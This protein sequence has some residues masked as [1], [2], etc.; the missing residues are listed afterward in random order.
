MAISE[1]MRPRTTAEAGRSRQIPRQ[2]GGRRGRR[3]IRDWGSDVA[4]SLYQGRNLPAIVVLTVVEG[5]VNNFLPHSGG[6]I[7]QS[8][9][10]DAR[11][12]GRCGAVT[13][14]AG[15]A[16]KRV[17]ASAPDPS[18]SLDVRSSAGRPQRLP[19][20]WGRRFTKQLDGRKK[21]R[22]GLTRAASTSTC[23]SFVLSGGGL[24]VLLKNCRVPIG[25]PLER[26]CAGRRG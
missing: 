19:A 3:K 1:G 23:R 9:R 22:R 13:P 11:R 12:R 2:A 26:P 18:P 21:G 25:E 10:L 20:G 4:A 15:D 5:Q 6:L 17:I 8:P 14:A 16:L 7:P 24:P